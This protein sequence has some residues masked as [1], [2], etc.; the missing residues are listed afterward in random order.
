MQIS[1]INK[2]SLL[3]Y[4]GKTSCIVFTPGCN[5]R[6]FFCHNPEFVLPELLKNTIKDLISEKAFFNFLEKRKWLLDWV[7]ICWWE[8]T[9]QKD[10]EEFCKKIKEMWFLV[11]LDTNGR[12]SDLL[13]RLIDDKLVD[14]IAMDVKNILSKYEHITWIEENSDKYLSSIRLLISSEIDY[15]F[16]TTVVKWMHSI[17][18]IK[19][20]MET[21]KWAKNYFLQNY[22]KG[23][24]IK[25]NF[26]GESF[27]LEELEEFK[28]I[29]EKY[30]KKIWIRE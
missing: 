24:T 12:N 21:L 4:P 20:I 9:L 13:K 7:S 29:W 11:K 8:P 10:L 6:C 16:R 5:L 28:R 2:F 25:Q 19:N 23:K 27:R 14:Y 30:I 22:R 26:E 1:W 18:D 3:E 15:E 17:E